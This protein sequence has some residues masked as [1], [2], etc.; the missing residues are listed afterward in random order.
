MPDVGRRLS[1][2]HG[3]P[4]DRPAPAASNGAAT[5]KHRGVPMPRLALEPGSRLL[6]AAFF[7][8]S[9]CGDARHGRELIVSLSIVRIAGASLALFVFAL[10]AQTLSRGAATIDPIVVTATRAPQPLS[11]LLADVTVIE[12]EEIARA[13]SA[14]LI[15]LLQRAPGVEI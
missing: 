8:H 1:G 9:S 12:A 5:G 15:E 7:R 11:Q 2:E 6:P 4:G 14:S 13:G 10:H 3:K